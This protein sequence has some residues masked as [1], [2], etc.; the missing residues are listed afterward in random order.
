VKLVKNKFLYWSK[1]STGCLEERVCELER[2]END[3]LETVQDQHYF[4]LH[5]QKSFRIC[6]FSRA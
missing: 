6:I 3:H 5:L 2:L 4:E 1:P